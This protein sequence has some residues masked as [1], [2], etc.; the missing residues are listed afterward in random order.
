MALSLAI[1]STIRSSSALG[2]LVILSRY[3]VDIQFSEVFSFGKT[4]RPPQKAAHCPKRTCAA[5]VTR[6]PLSGETSQPQKL[7]AN[8]SDGFWGRSRGSSPPPSEIVHA[9]YAIAWANSAESRPR[10]VLSRRRFIPGHS[11]LEQM[12][13]ATVTQR[14][15]PIKTTGLMAAARRKKRD[16]GRVRV[17]RLMLKV[18]PRGLIQRHFAE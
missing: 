14:T 3:S 15:P 5:T 6:V 2:I 16:I 17:N 9:G 18:N 10:D 12:G 13:L 11:G 7:P 4:K 8:P 1:P